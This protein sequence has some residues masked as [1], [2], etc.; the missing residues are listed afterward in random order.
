[1]LEDDKEAAKWYRKAA[2]QGNAYGQQ[3]LGVMYSE[4]EGVEKDAKEAVK[5]YRKAAEQGNA[6]GQYWLA[7]MY[8]KGV[9]VLEDEKEASKWFR[10]AAHQGH[11]SS[12]FNLGLHFQYGVGGVRQDYVYA[13][14][15]YNIAAANGKTMAQKQ[16]L[17]RA[18][19]MTPD[20]ITKAEELSKEMT[21][22]NPK[23]IKR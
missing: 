14:A 19:K 3:E 22:K 15:W 18:K 8:W 17:K 2:E 11:A 10:K 9:G 5:W 21:T 20:Q 16:K 7:Q 4:G 6:N 12:Q 1:M 13:Y 23:L